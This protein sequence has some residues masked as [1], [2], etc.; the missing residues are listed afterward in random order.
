MGVFN[1]LVG[2][3]SSHEPSLG[4]VI[5][6]RILFS[7]ENLRLEPYSQCL[8]SAAR[9]LDTWWPVRHQLLHVYTVALA[10]SDSLDE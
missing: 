10:V 1:Q 8:C 4:S 5:D 7:A 2:N 3:M 6:L 9:I